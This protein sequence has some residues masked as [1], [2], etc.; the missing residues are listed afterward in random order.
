MSQDLQALLVSYAYVGACVLVGEVAA[1]RG[2]SREFSRKL[3]HVSVGLWVFGALALF[4]H[5]ELAVVPSLTAAVANWVI[6]RKR[7]LK[8]VETEPDNLGTVWFALSFSVC[9]WVAWD[10]PSVAAGSLLAMVVGDALASLVGRRFGRHRYET[11][12]GERKSLEGSLAM[13][14]G[15]FLAVLA[16]L[17]WMPGL[18]PDMPRVSLAVL[19]AVVA[20]CAEALGIRGRDNLW[21]PLSALA[22]LAWTP[23]AYATGLGMGAGVALLIG[24]AAWLRGSLSPSGVLGAIV[25]G[26]PVF[27]LAGTVGVAAL[28]G[29]FF[30][31]SALSKAFR[32]RKAGVEAEYAKTGTRDLG[33]ALANGGVAALAAVLLALTGDSRYLLAMLGALVAANAD[34]WATELGVLSRSPPR[35][36]TTLRPVAPGTSGAV[37]GVGLL[38]STAGAAFVGILALLAG[39]S[40]KLLPWLVLAGVVG[41]LVD[42]FLGATVQDVRWCEPCARETERRIHRCGQPTRALRGLSWLGNDT[43]N[44]VATA[45][46][47]L[48][49]FWA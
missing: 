24:V 47:A 23:T 36:I 3:I 49:A 9:L 19:C 13:L 37:S 29:F 4:E 1:R 25:V 30:S 42:S 10:Q 48:L 39:L 7:L 22:V 16:V 21:V 44:G 18:S 31:S 26:A 20:T 46:G 40:W 33:Q 41:S 27:G 5:R 38:A 14:A 43:V 12:S 35:L 6:H 8:A 17:T 28:L 32:E 2:V 45:A 11:L 15:T 34:T